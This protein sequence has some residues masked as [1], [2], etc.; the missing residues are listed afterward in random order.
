MMVDR[1][2]LEARLAEDHQG[3]SLRRPV[4][5][6]LASFFCAEGVNPFVQ[7]PSEGSRP[8]WEV[9]FEEAI[10]G[11][12]R[13]EKLHFFCWLEASGA[14][15]AR[16]DDAPGVT[17]GDN[18][19]PG[20]EESDGDGAMGMAAAAAKEVAPRTI[21]IPALKEAQYVCAAT[22]FVVYTSKI[23]SLDEQSWWLS[24][25]QGPS[26]R[27]A[28]VPILALPQYARLTKT[29]LQVRYLERVL[30]LD[31]ESELD[32]WGEETASL[33]GH[34]GLLWAS[35][36]LIKVLNSS[37]KMCPVWAMRRRYLELYFFTNHVGLGLPV[38]LCQ[39]SMLEAVAAFRSVRNVPTDGFG[40]EGS[41]APAAVTA[42]PMMSASQFAE[43]ARVLTD[44]VHEAVRDV[45]DGPPGEGHGFKPKAKHSSTRS[46]QR[47][48]R[49]RQPTL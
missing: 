32:R 36:R 47:A 12:S 24:Q 45:L 18:I 37:Q 21:V 19:S 48:V 27:S 29:S 40:S 13:E 22:A 2:V 15:S 41:D 25:Q 20:A 23:C 43:L 38:E 1:S 33:L 34:V 16:R 26:G 7:W 30:A 8:I 42:P 5:E 10:E 14:L 28:G 39:L 3:W 9:A 44:A 6:K 46:R 35:L 4:R 11:H 49:K 17:L 31:S